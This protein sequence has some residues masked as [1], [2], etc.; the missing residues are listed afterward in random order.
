MR[1]RSSSLGRFIDAAEHAFTARADGEPSHRAVAESFQRLKHARGAKHEDG[2]RLPV[3]KRHLV[4]AT[5]LRRFQEPDL[6]TLMVAFKA[7]EP[8]LMWRQRAGGGQAASENFA[9]SHANAMIV[10][11]GALEPRTD[12]WLGVSLLAPHVR[13]PDHHHPPEEVYLVMSSGEFSQGAGPWFE[14][15]VGGS[16]H[17]PPG[18]LHA[19]RSGATPLLAFWLLRPTETPERPG[20]I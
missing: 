2:A 14:P 9:Q 7:I 4:E 8:M 11:P 19:M 13:Y 3:C 1:M 15:G 12:V 6:A 17:N 5:D 16:F 18:I 20:P 10:G